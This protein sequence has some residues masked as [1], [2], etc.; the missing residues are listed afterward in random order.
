MRI[1]KK[2][3]NA[4]NRAPERIAQK[5][6]S[7]KLPVRNETSYAIYVENTACPACAKLTTRV[8]RQTSTKEIDI[9]L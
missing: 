7:Q 1:K 5:S 9:K 2:S 8:E 4:P 3:M 6:A